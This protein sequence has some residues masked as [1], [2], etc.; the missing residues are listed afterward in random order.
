MV[1]Y[2]DYIGMSICFDGNLMVLGAL[3]LIG[4]GK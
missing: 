4:N 1:N 3:V 2:S